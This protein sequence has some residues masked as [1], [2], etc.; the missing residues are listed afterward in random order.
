MKKFFIILIFASLFLL[1]PKLQ[2]AASPVLNFSDLINGPKTGLNDGLGEGAIVTIWG[3]NLG[4]T[5]GSSK[6]YFKDAQNNIIEAAHVYYWKNADGQLPG[7]PSDLYTHHRM[8]EIAFSIPATAADGAGKIFV[9]VDGVDSGELEFT[10][11]SGNIFYLKSVGSDIASCGTWQSPCASFK[12]LTNNRMKTGDTAYVV[13]N[14]TNSCVWG[15]PNTQIGTAL[16][17]YAFIS[18]PNATAACSGATYG[19]GIFNGVNSRYLVHSK[20]KILTDGGNNFGYGARVVG[21]EFTDITCANGQSA[22]ITST[23][24]EGDDKYLG[25]YVHD[26]GGTC[27]GNLHHTTYMSKRNAVSDTPAFEMG[28]NNFVNN[29]ARGGIHIYDEHQCGGYSGVIKIHNNFIKDQASACLNVHANIC[30]ENKYISGE[31]EFYNNILVNCGQKGV[32]PGQDYSGPAIQL[33]GAGNVMNVKLYNNDI[34]GYGYE[35]SAAA[36]NVAVFVSPATYAAHMSYPFAGTWSWVNNIVYDV[37]DLPYQMTA[38]PNKAPVNTANNIWHNGGDAFP[39]NAPSWDSGVLTVNPLFVNSM[40]GDFSLQAD[41]PAINTGANLNFPTTDFF[42]T[43]RPQ[44]ARF[45]IGAFENV[46]DNTPVATCTDSIQNQN[47]TATDCGGACPACA[48]MTAPG[49]PSGV[50]V[51]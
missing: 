32:Y 35:G 27:T 19:V 33:T 38:Y 29:Q 28:W 5:Q 13:D 1:T 10:I 12:Y 46:N 47:E 26:F 24:N 14:I 8:Q 18:Y 23:K 11:R 41:S 7:G 9:R 20:I 31:I 16:S 3:N 17:P 44:G 36:E 40:S 49:A 6:V 50:R 42:N 30:D 15:W 2:A 51:E 39:L 48:D 34:Y 22:A 21:S 45:D 25:N 4:N 37:N 43:P